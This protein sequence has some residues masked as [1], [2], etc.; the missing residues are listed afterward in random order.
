MILTCAA[1]VRPC[2]KNMT[3]VNAKSSLI[4]HMAM[5]QSKLGIV[6]KLE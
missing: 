3:N 2:C 1:G 6:A 4:S 5:M